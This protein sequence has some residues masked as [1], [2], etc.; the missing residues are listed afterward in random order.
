MNGLRARIS[1]DQIAELTTAK[2]RIRNPS[3]VETIINDLIHGGTKRLQV[4]SD[5]DHTITKQGKVNGRNV[6]SSFGIL[7]SCKSLSTEYIQKSKSLY[8]KYRP[9][10][11][12]PKLDMDTKIKL[13]IEWWSQ[14]S[15]NLKCV[16]YPRLAF[17]PLN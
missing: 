5:F 10:E 3:R 4:I 13:M 7:D 6:E 14:T 2:C 17:L 11:V 8:L 9:M 16:A 1:I 15:D 12:D